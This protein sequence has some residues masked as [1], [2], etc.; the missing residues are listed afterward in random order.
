[1]RVRKEI[2]KV[3]LDWYF[4]GFS[5]RKIQKQIGLVFGES[6]SH[7]AIWKWIM[8]YSKLV[9]EYVDSIPVENHSGLWHVDETMVNCL[10]GEDRFRWFWQVI[11]EKSRFL[12][13]TQL[14]TT[15]KPKDVKALFSQCDERAGRP[16]TIFVDGMQTYKRGF[17]KVY[18]SR[19]GS[20][21]VKFVRKCGI[22]AR[23]TNNIVERIH[24]TLKDRTKV[25]RGMKSMRTARRLL[26][27]WYVHYNFVRVHSAIKTTPAQQAGI[28]VDVS[29]RW[30]SLIEQ[31]TRFQSLRN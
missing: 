8:K 6:V 14:T 27:G 21:K 30:G 26:D 20:D 15:K 22:K 23:Q 3:A 10:D 1:M 17:N 9:K 2:I 31:A 7:L 12:I 24:G 29:E 11:D 18:Y 4:E 16:S 5:T 25:M 19:Y 28:D 13:A